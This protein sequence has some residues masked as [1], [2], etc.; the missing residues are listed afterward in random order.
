MSLEPLK[1]MRS[2]AQQH[3]FFSK[4]TLV[5]KSPLEIENV[6]TRENT[7]PTKPKCRHTR[8]LRLAEHV[9]I[10]LK[11][12][13][14]ANRTRR[15]RLSSTEW[16]ASTQDVGN[17]LGPR[18]PGLLDQITW[19][20]HQLLWP[21]VAKIRFILLGFVP[22]IV[23][24]WCWIKNFIVAILAQAILLMGPARKSTG[25]GQAPNTFFSKKLRWFGGFESDTYI[26][27]IYIWPRA[28]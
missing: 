13:Q 18:R 10:P 19:D 14:L 21:Q 20:G 17:T 28:N 23:H 4:T 25:S 2:W 7:V 16:K 1:N 27:Y 24:G 12:S 8:H 11:K 6:P 3:V 5:E 15:C 26:I 9:A 22:A